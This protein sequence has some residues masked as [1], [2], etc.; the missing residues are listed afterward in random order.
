LR[1]LENG[2]KGGKIYKFLALLK[3]NTQK[4]E[5]LKIVLASIQKLYWIQELKK[6]IHKICVE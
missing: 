5:K 4:L 2:G 3:E 1:K 6:C